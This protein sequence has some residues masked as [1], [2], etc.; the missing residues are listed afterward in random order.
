MVPKIAVS[1][2]HFP[3]ED[4]K[5]IEYPANVQVATLLHSLFV[6]NGFACD[7]FKGMLIEKVKGINAWGATAAVECHFNQLHW[8]FD[9]KE[10]G[11]GFETCVWPKSLKAKAWAGHVLTEFGER[12]PFDRRGT[13]I[14]ERGDLYF[15]KHTHCPALIIEPLFLDNPLE[16]VFLK[17]KRGYEFIAASVFHG[18]VR[19]LSE[20]PT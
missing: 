14:L 5:D 4:K 1:V 17:M 16:S 18:T 2:G 7:I 13:G 10:Y 20:N 19:W 3:G 8:P 11:A 6:V 9:P 15:C 12:L